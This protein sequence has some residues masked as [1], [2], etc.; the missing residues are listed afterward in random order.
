MVVQLE[1]E[2]ELDSKFST[3]GTGCGQ[4]RNVFRISEEAKAK[5]C[6]M[7]IS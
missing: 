3:W 7:D 5:V 4:K 2:L 1:V 6:T